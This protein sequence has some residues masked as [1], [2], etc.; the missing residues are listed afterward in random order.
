[1][2]QGSDKHGAKR[3]DELKH[4]VQGELRGGRVTHAQEWREP[5]P[6]GEDQPPADRRLVGDRI[7]GTDAP[8]S[9]EDVARVREDLAKHLQR[10][11]FPADREKIVAQLA[12][13]QAPDYLIQQVGELPAT[14]RY[15]SLNALLEAMGYGV[16]ETR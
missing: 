7:P 10:S 13:Y 2:Q 9:P 5:E 6:S 3:D 14:E 1:M 11:A 15:A 16:P 8:P 4:E 12:D